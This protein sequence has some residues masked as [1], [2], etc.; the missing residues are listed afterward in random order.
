[1][2]AERFRDAYQRL[3]LLDERL[4]HKLR[5]SRRMSMGPATQQQLEER[6]ETLA[7][8]TLELKGVVRDLFRAIASTRKPAE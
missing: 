2:D 8:Y 4:A 3:E 1:M 6:L 7:S 5:K